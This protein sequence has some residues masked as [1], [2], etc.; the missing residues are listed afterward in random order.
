MLLNF[1]C[2]VHYPNWTNNPKTQTIPGLLAP[3]WQPDCQLSRWFICA[4]LRDPGRD[5]PCEDRAE[6]FF[7]NPSFVR[8]LCSLRNTIRVSHQFF[9][10]QITITL[11]LWYLILFSFMKCFVDENSYIYFAWQFKLMGSEIWHILCFRHFLGFLAPPI[12]ALSHS[13][14]PHLLMDDYLQLDLL[15]VF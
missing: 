1:C 7:C 6:G 11:V 12:S 13:N 14:L 9:Y 3:M 4:S 2:P 8:A 15:L 5:V 10:Q